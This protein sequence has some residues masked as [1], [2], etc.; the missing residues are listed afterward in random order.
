MK[1]Y[2]VENGWQGSAMVRCLIIAP[3]EATALQLAEIQY[4]QAAPHDM[5]KD[6]L[7]EMGVESYYNKLEVELLCDDTTAVW[8]G[9]VNSG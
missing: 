9:E 7:L 4:R 5:A 6:D 1:L 3:D 2:Q 8:V